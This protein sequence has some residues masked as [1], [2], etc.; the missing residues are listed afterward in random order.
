MQNLLKIASLDKIHDQV[1]SAL[2]GEV[3]R[4]FGQIGVVKAGKNA[5]FDAE[6]LGHLLAFKVGGGAA[7][8]AGQHF[9]D[10]ADT[11]FQTAIAGLVDRAHAALADQF[12]DLVPL[13]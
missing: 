2:R 3:V 8:E 9:L 1:F 12:Q 10:R 6:L 4:D 7:G 13:A 11:A 5:G